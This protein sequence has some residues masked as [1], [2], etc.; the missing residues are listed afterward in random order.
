MKD[1]KKR[2]WAI[3]LAMWLLSKT[4]NIMH[5]TNWLNS[6]SGLASVLSP[7]VSPEEKARVR[8]FVEREIVTIQRYLDE[9][10][11]TDVSSSSQTWPPVKRARKTEKPMSVEQC[12]LRRIPNEM[13]HER[14]WLLNM[15]RKFKYHTNAP[16]SLRDALNLMREDPS[17]PVAGSSEDGDVECSKGECGDVG[18]VS[19][20]QRL[21]FKSPYT[22]YPA[23]TFGNPM[24]V[25][26]KSVVRSSASRHS[27]SVGVPLAV[28]SPYPAMN[29][30]K[31][32]IPMHV[33]AVPSN[34][35]WPPTRKR[36][37]SPSFQNIPRQNSAEAAEQAVKALMMMGRGSSDASFSSST[38]SSSSSQT[39]SPGNQV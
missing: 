39:W 27:S 32:H 11:L 10:S 33:T 12:V 29:M 23:S 8:K 37:R 17:I 34:Q 1:H 20:F 25:P 15:V 19:N 16:V 7:R 30:K 6:S 21:S 24:I 3:Y 36:E 4:N 9:S 13:N 18:V 22:Q 35:T 38:S 31:T 5:L 28:P 14:N 26:A 2:L